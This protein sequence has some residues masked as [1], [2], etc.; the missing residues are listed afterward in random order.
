VNGKT[1]EVQAS[2]QHEF[3][4]QMVGTILDACRA[5]TDKWHGFRTPDRWRGPPLE[6]TGMEKLAEFFKDLGELRSKTREALLA[7]QELVDPS[8]QAPS[9]LDR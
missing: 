9:I 2:L 1:S 5:V 7:L 6:N 4:R 3:S 8:L